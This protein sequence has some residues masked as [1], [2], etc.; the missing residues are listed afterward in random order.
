MILISLTLIILFLGIWTHPG[1]ETI[2]L[3][4]I[5]SVIQNC[6]MSSPELQLMLL[7]FGI[8]S[9]AGAAYF[10]NINLKRKVIRYI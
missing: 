10:K 5:P 8:S 6:S 1:C 4:R 3:L 7:P 9:D 2:G